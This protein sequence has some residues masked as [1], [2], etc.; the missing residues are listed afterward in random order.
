MSVEPTIICD[1]CAAI[2]AGGRTARDARESVKGTGCLLAQPG[3]LDY[4]WTCS[5]DI[6]AE[7]Q[8]DRCVVVTGAGTP[9]RVL[10]DGEPT[11]E[12]VRAAAAILEAAQRIELTPEQIERQRAAKV[13]IRARNERI[14]TEQR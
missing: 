8:G 13:R 4:C 6:E 1:R 14:R 12:D 9:A 2:I 3:G 5:P 11:D 7:R 10:F